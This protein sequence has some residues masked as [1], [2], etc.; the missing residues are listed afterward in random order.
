MADAESAREIF[1]MNYTHLVGITFLY[2]DHLITL[3]NEINLLWR[4]RKALS[5]C[6]FFLNRY[7]AFISGIPVAMLPFLT[8][9]KQMCLNLTFFREV[10]LLVTQTIVSIIMVIRVY[11]LFGRN[12]R[13]LWFTLGLGSCAVGVTVWS[14]TG[15][16]G[17]RPM[18]LG[19][20]HF[21]IMQ[22]TAFRLAGCWEALF[23]FDSVI[24]G[25]TIYNACITLRRMGT[26]GNLHTLVVRDGA[27]Y[28]GIMALAN[29]ANIAT[30]YFARPVSPGSLAGFANCISVTMISRLILHL[31]KHANVGILTEPVVQNNLPLGSF[32]DILMTEADHGSQHP[33]YSR[34]PRS[35]YV[36]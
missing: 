4:R 20:C 9:S 29:L 17:S 34:D 6:W 19:G 21:D 24:F 3:D 35:G 32:D 28:F 5:A 14:V 30:Y 18:V 15:Q 7:F 31:H 33:T 23:I 13:V 2:W 10:A 26:Q 16:H 12:R 22:S 1:L 8:V 25:L 27:L 11:A 36:S